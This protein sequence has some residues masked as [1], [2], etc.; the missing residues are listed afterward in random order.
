MCHGHYK[1][2]TVSG[3]EAYGSGSLHFCFERASGEGWTSARFRLSCRGQQNM[4]ANSI[5]KELV[6]RACGDYCRINYL[7]E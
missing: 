4:S 7:E 6:Q 1:G 3:V 5:L 2:N